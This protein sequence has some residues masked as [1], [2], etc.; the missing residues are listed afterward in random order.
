[1]TQFA[2]STHTGL[3]RDH[4]ED[5][6][7]ADPDCGIYLVADGVGGHSFGEVASSIVKNTVTQSY[8]DG[9]S[10]IDSIHK[11]H[12][13][14]LEEIRRREENLGMGSTVVACAIRGCE[15]EVGWVGDS[16]AYLWNG[17]NLQLLTRD[18]THVFDLVDEGIISLAEAFSHPE[19]HVLTQSMGVFE[20]MDLAPGCVQGRIEN[21]EQIL[22][23]S[24]GLTDELSDNAIAVQLR[25]NSSTQ[26][27]VDGLI[28]AALSSGGR[29]NVTVL[30]VGEA[31]CDP[32]EDDPER[33]PDLN[34]T[35]EIGVAPNSSPRED[36]SGKFWSV[37][38]GLVAL[39]A[40]AWFLG[41]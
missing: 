24:D 33:K 2:A 3:H 5:C 26:S 12:S 38:L 40:V 17:E 32:E 22:L 34:T 1:M 6:Y 35:Q 25:R 41:T 27:Q 21:G 7:A 13:A 4:N 11:A 31:L 20:E 28:N 19:R 18:H 15:Y 39:S 10:L 9:G 16:R 8:S 14:V 23:C 37:L 36:H 29:D 30:V